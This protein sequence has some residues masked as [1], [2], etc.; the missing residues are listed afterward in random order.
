M[1]KVRDWKDRFDP[2]ADYVFLKNLRLFSGRVRPGDPVPKTLGRHR[3]KIWYRG[4][5]ICRA[6]SRNAPARM[7]EPKP[8]VEKRGG[9]YRVTFPDGR[10]E[11]VRKA[12]LQ[13]MGL[14][15][16]Q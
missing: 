16:S 4:G 12:Q 7:G 10:V 9:W 13:E 1:G 5:F 2:E 11:N 15:E 14:D 3:L 8:V 6:D